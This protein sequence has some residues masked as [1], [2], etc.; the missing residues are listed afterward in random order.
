[1]GVGRFV[2]TPLPLMQEQTGVSHSDTAL[3]ATANY[4][5]YFLGAIALAVFRPARAR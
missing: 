5:G 1:M 2:Y 3:V 4:L